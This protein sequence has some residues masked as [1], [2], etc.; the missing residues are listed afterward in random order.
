[1]EHAALNRMNVF[2]NLFPRGSGGG[3]ITVKTTGTDDSKETHTAKL[4]HVCTQTMTADLRPRQLQDKIP[5]SG[6]S[7][8]HKA[9]LRVWF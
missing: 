6:R 1:M 7:S 3:G 4:I 2:M 8:E 9:L 5:A